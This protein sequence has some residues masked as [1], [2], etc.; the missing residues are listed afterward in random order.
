MQL[1]VEKS[2]FPLENQWDESLDQILSECTINS[3]T[4]YR[5]DEK[6]RDLD[7][8]KIFQYFYFPLRKTTKIQMASISD[9]KGWNNIMHMTWFCHYPTCNNEPCGTC[10][11]CLAVI[12]EGFDWRIS[13]KRR[14]ISFYYRRIIWPSKSYLKSVL[15]SLGIRK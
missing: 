10:N 15:T 5:V 2:E 3:Q 11:P 8:Y 12:K 7:M 14:A 6:F 13:P 9:K 1:S 4:V